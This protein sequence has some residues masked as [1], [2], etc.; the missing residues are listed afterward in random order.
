ML[1]F[2]LPMLVAL[3]AT[4]VGVRGINHQ[5]VLIAVRASA[6]VGGLAFILPFTA[7]GALTFRSSALTRYLRGRRRYFGIVFAFAMFVH[8]TCVACLFHVNPDQP[9]NQPMFIMGAVAYLFIVALFA[10]SFDRTTDWIGPRNWRL[11]H[12]TGV[13]YVW[14]YFMLVL[15]KASR[16]MT[17]LFG[18]LLVLMVV[19]AGLRWMRY[20]RYLV[21]PATVNG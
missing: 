12:L 7:S 5:S 19:A 18:P 17:A 13:W 1:A 20:N 16:S 15:L 11:L 4:I 8:L 6:F 21:Q 14:G 2:V 3:P 10:T 9:V